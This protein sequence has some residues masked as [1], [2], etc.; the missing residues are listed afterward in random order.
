MFSVIRS[1]LAFL[2]LFCITAHAQ[3]AGNQT[4]INAGKH[5]A[6]VCF[7]CHNES[8]IAIVT[9]VPNLAGQKRDY[10][11]NAL[12]AYR[13]GETRRNPIMNAMAQPLSDAD[14]SNISAYYGSL[15]LKILVQ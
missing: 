6:A 3:T 11:E 7:A 2:T 10:L 12:R 15:P 8:G 9:G 13:D 14:V 4:A 1:K 5:R